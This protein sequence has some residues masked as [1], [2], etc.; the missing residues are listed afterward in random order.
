MSPKLPSIE[1]SLP[2]KKTFFYGGS[3]HDPTS[4]EVRETINPGNG[5]VIDSIPQAK[6]E[7]VNLEILLVYLL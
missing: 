6:A 2:K 4:N 5:S 7:D 3:W 1:E